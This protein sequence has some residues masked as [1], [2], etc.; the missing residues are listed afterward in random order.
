MSSQE[1]IAAA[2]IPHMILWVGR[3]FIDLSSAGYRDGYIKSAI[4][5]T[6][7]GTL[8]TFYHPLWLI[9][10]SCV[11][12]P[13]VLVILY[14]FFHHYP[15]LPLSSRISFVFPIALPLCH[16]YSAAVSTDLH[17]HY[18]IHFHPCPPPL[19]YCVSGSTVIINMILLFVFHLTLS[20]PYRI[21][22][23]SIL[24]ILHLYRISAPVVAIVKHI[25]SFCQHNTESL[26]VL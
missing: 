16:V 23:S 22:A 17:L 20:P 3:L 11:S 13:D 18:H 10:S 7:S 19:S 21:S 5:V 8:T 26:L 4:A 2:S 25:C 12:T 24:V 15:M 14:I 6:T 9:L 1:T